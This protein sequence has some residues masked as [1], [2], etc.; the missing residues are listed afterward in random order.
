MAQIMAGDRIPLAVKLY[1]QNPAEQVKV[2]LYNAYGELF[3][4]TYLFHVDKGLY[5]NNEETMPEF[6]LMAVY[7]FMKSEEYADSA[8]KFYSIPKTKEPEKFVT[9]MVKMIQTNSDHITG[10]VHEITDSE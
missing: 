5:V 2:D 4:T 8:E 9:G 10:R 7:T 3:K 6:D 1:D